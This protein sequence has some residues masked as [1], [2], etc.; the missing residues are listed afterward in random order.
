MAGSF[1]SEPREKTG[2]AAAAS[3]VT[4]PVPVMQS[5][6]TSPGS[7]RARWSSRLAATAPKDRGGGR[8]RPGRAAGKGRGAASAPVEARRAY[9]R[10]RPSIRTAAEGLSAN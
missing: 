2:K 1:M 9:S 10:F 6:T 4:V 5:M 3:P 7:G 8:V